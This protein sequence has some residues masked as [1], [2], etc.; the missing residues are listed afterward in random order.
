L[1]ASRLA[2]NAV[3]LSGVLFQSITHMAPGIAVAF[4]ILFTAG[5][6]GGST[7]LAV[8]FALIGCLCVA[9]S[10]GQLAQYL[11]SAGGL[12]TYTAN[13]LGPQVGFLV[14]WGYMLSEP[15]V[16]AFVYLVFGNLVASTFESTWSW[17]A[18]IWAPAVVLIGVV[19]WY[20]VYVGIKI[21]TEAGVLLGIFEI[22]VFVALALT[23]IVKAG[24]HNSIQVFGLQYHNDKGL[25][26]VFPGMIYAVLAFIGF[27]ASAPL[28]EEAE[29]PR[30]TIPRAVIYS[31][32]LIGAFYLLCYYAATVYFGPAR[33]ASSFIGFNHGDPWTGMTKQ[34]WN[35][36]WVIVFLALV[37]SSVANANAGANAATR[38]AYAMA[39][40]RLLP[41]ALASV[42]AQHRTPYIAIHVQAIG[43]IALALFLGALLKGAPL[44]GV[45]L[46][47]TVA[48]LIVIVIYM[49]VNLSCIV[50]FWRFRRT[51][52]NLL[53]HAIIPIVGILFFVPAEIISFGI[54]FANLGISALTW[55]ANY[56][57]WICLVW[58][59][60]GIGLLV[61]FSA[62]RPARVQETADVYMEEILPEEA[63]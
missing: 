49:L 4:S 61:Y 3:G 63:S 9:V 20:L 15:I 22:V 39:R 17:P 55:P 27:E 25:G 48:T 34:V 40:I 11:P 24:G 21:S 36:G 45:A 30:R 57:P 41:S 28:G 38:A 14:A 10:I 7:P 2:H 16:A 43:G 62:T 8:L 13:G 54:N 19:V 23:L 18:W 59:I 53:L 37:N 52:F 44:N 6:A 5:Y 32:L 46:L 51:D 12:Y 26:S 29:N 33:M 35:W 60:L 47:G 58:V 42:H 1:E 31:C 50:Y 56:A